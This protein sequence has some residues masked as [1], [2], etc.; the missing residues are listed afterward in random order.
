M[1]RNILVVTDNLLGYETL[2]K[3]YLDFF[4]FTYKE[5]CINDVCDCALVIANADALENDKVVKQEKKDGSGFGFFKEPL[6]YVCT[7]TLFFYLCA[8]QGVIGWMITY[9]KDTGLISEGLAQITASVLWVMILAGRLS[10]AWLSTRVRKSNLLR[11][12]Y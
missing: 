7:L 8:E 6:F 10:T 3:P 9:F 4:G 1:N 5:V 11:I 12:M 2:L